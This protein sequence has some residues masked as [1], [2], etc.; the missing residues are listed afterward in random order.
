MVGQDQQAPDGISNAIEGQ[1]EISSKVSSPNWPTS[2]SAGKKV[3]VD[4]S[5]IVQYTSEEK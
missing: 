3:V 5:S 1:Q 4:P 2:R